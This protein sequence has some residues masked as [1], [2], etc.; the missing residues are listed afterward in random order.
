MSDSL[1][2]DMSI[3]KNLKKLR[4]QVGLTQQQAAA[5]LETRGIPVS[6]DILAKMEQGK[7]SIRISALRA[8]KEIYKVD[9]FDRF[10]E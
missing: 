8:M 2:Q 4:A 7:Y 1:K 9:S 3:G 10:F 5:Q 6:A